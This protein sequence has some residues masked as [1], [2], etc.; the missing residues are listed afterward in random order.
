MIANAAYIELV[1]KL[2]DTF[3]M[4]LNEV[5]QL[6]QKEKNSKLS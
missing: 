5:K 2:V 4:L 3:V 6:D 1:N